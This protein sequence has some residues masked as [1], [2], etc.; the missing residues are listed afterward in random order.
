[1]MRREQWGRED[2]GRA[3]GPSRAPDRVVLVWGGATLLRRGA[4]GRPSQGSHPPWRYEP[5][6]EGVRLQ[7]ELGHRRRS[8]SRGR[9]GCSPEILL[10]ERRWGRSGGAPA[11]GGRRRGQRSASRRRSGSRGRKGCLSEIL[12]R[13]Q[14]AACRVGGAPVG[15]EEKHVI[16]EMRLTCGTA[17][18]GPQPTFSPPT[19]Q[20]TRIIPTQ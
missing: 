1:M 10:R 19:K 20:K 12:L 6:A 7:A 11:G 3:G 9:W 2:R 15:E 4:R 8:G 18:Q 17:C 5:G 16:R 14:A 13:V